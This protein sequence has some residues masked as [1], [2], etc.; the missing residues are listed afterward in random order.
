MFKPH[1]IHFSDLLRLKDAYYGHSP[2]TLCI[3]LGAGMRQHMR[4]TVKDYNIHCGSR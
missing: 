4:E 1:P 3:S 2:S